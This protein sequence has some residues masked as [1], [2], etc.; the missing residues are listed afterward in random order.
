MARHSEA[1]FWRS[2]EADHVAGADEQYKRGDYSRVAQ[3]LDS[4]NNCAGQAR[5]Y[6]IIEDQDRTP[7]ERN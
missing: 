6:E 3:M 5:F 2:L 1:Q 4:A 7:P